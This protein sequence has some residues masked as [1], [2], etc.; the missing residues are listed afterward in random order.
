MEGEDEGVGFDDVGSAGGGG[1][2]CCCCCCDGGGNMAVLL[3]GDVDRGATYW[4]GASDSR[5]AKGWSSGFVGVEMA[6]WVF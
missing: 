4:F 3:D 2:C 6:F 1:S 5:N